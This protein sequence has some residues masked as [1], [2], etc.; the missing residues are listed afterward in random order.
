MYIMITKYKKRLIFGYA[1]F[2]N[3]F[4][5][6]FTKNIIQLISSETTFQG[7]IALWHLFYDVQHSGSHL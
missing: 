3:E 6:V 2:S 1:G 7:G 5:N 4:T